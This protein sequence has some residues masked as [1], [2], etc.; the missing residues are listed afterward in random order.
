MTISARGNATLGKRGLFEQYEIFQENDVDNTLQ[1]ALVKRGI[2]MLSNTRT[3]G[4]A[5]VPSLAMHKRRS[6]HEDESTQDEGWYFEESHKP[7]PSSTAEQRDTQDDT[8][9][10]ASEPDELYFLETSPTLTSPPE[11]TQTSAAKTM[12][13]VST[14]T[15]LSTSKDKSDNRVKVI[16]KAR[17]NGWAEIWIGPLGVCIQRG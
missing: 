12:Q 14:S 2:S 6:G 15:S 13:V 8:D 10:R 5:S 11:A 16:S 7:E 3:S 17:A 1:L 9:T 4:T